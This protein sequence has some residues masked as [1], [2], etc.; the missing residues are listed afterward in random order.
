MTDDKTLPSAERKRLQIVHAT[1][2]S[3]R[4]KLVKLADKLYNIRDL[5]RETPVGWTG[6]RKQQYFE[7]ASKVIS[8]K[9][10]ARFYTTLVLG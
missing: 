9:N 1:S 7:W 5:E 10:Q 2:A 6:E 8:S 3:P 4:A